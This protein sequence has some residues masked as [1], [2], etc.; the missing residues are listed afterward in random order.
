MTHYQFTHS[1]PEA[2][3]ERRKLLSR[4]FS[5]AA[6]LEFEP[7]IDTK[8]EATLK[9]WASRVIDDPVI[10]VYEW[11]HWLGFDIVCELNGAIDLLGGSFQ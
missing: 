9:Q 4:G 7:H 10:E 11:V 2:H 5:Q 1:N 3:K 8:I 6:M